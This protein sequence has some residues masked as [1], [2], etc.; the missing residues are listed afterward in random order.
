MTVR[1]TPRRIFALTL[2]LTAT[3]AAGSAA[4]QAASQY[5]FIECITEYDRSA[6]R[7]G[8]NDLSLWNSERARW[9][10]QCRSSEDW[11]VSC[12]LNS[13]TLTKHLS[14][15][16]GDMISRT[17]IDRHSGEYRR[18]FSYGSPVIGNCRPT[19]NPETAP[20]LF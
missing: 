15:R 16:T 5:S 4:A 3:L 20:R 1:D 9:E 18:S 11:L 13:H 2:A 17:T 19:E 8:Q 12:T 7:V 14:Q 10:D 6:Y